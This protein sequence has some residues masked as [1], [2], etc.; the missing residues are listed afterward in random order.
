M[1]RVLKYILIGFLTVVFMYL[2]ISFG[3]AKDK[4]FCGKV[5]D[6]DTGEPIEGAVVVVYW[7]EASW[8]PFGEWIVRLKDVKETLTDRKGEW[9]VKGPAGSGVNSLAYDTALMGVT[10]YTREPDFIVFKPGYCSWP[11]GFSIDTCRS[12]IRMI[13]GK[14]EGVGEGGTLQLPKLTKR[15]DRIEAQSIQIPEGEGCLESLTKLI[16]LINEER[17]NLGLPETLK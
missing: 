13:G 2:T 11:N 14:D 17:K 4:T 8:I 7:Y 6:A 10:F 3:Y 9:T 12:R 15:E 5:V 1:N 16:R